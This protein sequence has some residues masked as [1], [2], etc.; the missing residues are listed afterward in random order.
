[1]ETI[2]VEKYVGIED[3]MNLLSV[4]KGTL[5]KWIREDKF[6]GYKLGRYWRFKISEVEEWVQSK[7]NN[8]QF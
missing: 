8:I 3:V 6:P 5:Y 2:N 4:T 7:K 1:M